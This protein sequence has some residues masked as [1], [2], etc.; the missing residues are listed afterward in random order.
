VREQ[1]YEWVPRPPN[2]L[3]RIGAGVW[4]ATMLFAMANAVAGWR[5]F[6]GYD[7]VV[8]GVL[9]ISGLILLRFIPSA[10]RV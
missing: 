8:T 10:K 4:I 6:N 5:A 1:R 7:G 3:E 9:A 2:K